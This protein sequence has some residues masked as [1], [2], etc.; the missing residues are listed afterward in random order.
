MPSIEFK[1]SYLEVM[2]L[3]PHPQLSA[4][5]KKKVMEKAMRR[6][7]MLRAQVDEEGCGAVICAV[8]PPTA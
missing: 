3:S 7:R 6:E 2:G 1:D 5:I 8:V 4:F